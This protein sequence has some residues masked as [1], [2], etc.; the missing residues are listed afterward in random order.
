M[1]TWCLQP[2]GPA[3]GCELDAVTTD[4]IGNR[5]CL[6]TTVVGCIEVERR[7]SVLNLCC[8]LALSGATV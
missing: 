1:F 2:T 4:K 8:I 5:F 6:K 7:A 3:L